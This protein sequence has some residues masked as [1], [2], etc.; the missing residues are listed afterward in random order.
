MML[1]PGWLTAHESTIEE[2]T[3]FVCDSA[4]QPGSPFHAYRVRTMRADVTTSTRW[5][6]TEMEARQHFEHLVASH[7]QA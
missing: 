2:G 1:L 7:Y 5:C 4:R 3:L 6:E